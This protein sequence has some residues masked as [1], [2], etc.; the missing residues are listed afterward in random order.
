MKEINLNYIE[1]RIDKKRFELDTIWR[2]DKGAYILY[3]MYEGK[4]EFAEIW[5]RLI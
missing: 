4:G 5:I 3:D 1:H 2:C